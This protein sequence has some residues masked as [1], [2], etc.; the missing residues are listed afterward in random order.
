MKRQ[1]ILFAF[2]LCAASLMAVPALRSIKGEP[3]E[4]ERYGCHHQKKT[5]EEFVHRQATGKNRHSL[6]RQTPPRV[7]VILTEFKNKSFREENGKQV[8]EQ[9]FSGENVSVKRYFSDQSFGNYVPEFD[10]VGPV[11]L[12][13]NYEYYG[14]NIEG[15]DQYAEQMIIDA[16]KKADIEGVDFTEY[17]ADGDGYVDCIYVLYAGKGEADSKDENSIWPHNYRIEDIDLECILDGKHINVYVCSNE[18]NAGQKREGI[19]TAC[20]EFSHVLGLPDMYPTNGA[21]D[22]KTL[23]AWDLMDYGAYNNNGHTP[24]SYSAYE[25]WFMGWTEPYM[26]SSAMNF[27]LKDININGDCGIITADGQSNLNGLMPDPTEFV[28]I[29]NR[30]QTKGSWD[31]YL[32]GHGMLMTK[33]KFTYSRWQYNE[34]NNIEKDMSIDLIEADGFAPRY[35]WYWEGSVQMESD[36]GYRGKKGDAFP[37]GA[38]YYTPYK[39]YPITNIAE[40]DQIIRFDFCGG[41]S[42]CEVSFYSNSTYGSCST[43]SLKESSKGAGITLPAATA[44][45]SDYTFMGWATSKKSTTADAGKA[46]EKYY[47]MSDCTLYALWQDNSRWL[48][49]YTTYKGV[50]WDEGNTAY[51]KRGYDCDIY[52]IADEGYEVPTQKNCQVKVTCGNKAVG[53]YSFEDNRVHI[54]IPAAE[55]DDNIYISINNARVQ[56]GG[57]CEPYSHIF[58]GPC[59][60]GEQKLSGYYWTVSIQ[61]GEAN[62]DYDKTKGA[63][64]GSSK[65]PAQEVHL[66]TTETE[67][68]AVAQVIVNASIG[69]QGDGALNVY[70]GGNIVGQ[71]EYLETSPTEY[72]FTLA[73]P[74]TGMLDIRFVNTQKAIYVKSIDI[75]YAKNENI[76]TDLQP[77]D[78]CEY[79]IYSEDGTIYVNNINEPTN[80]MIYDAFGRNIVSEIYSEEYSTQ[81]PSGIYIIK[82]QRGNNIITKKLINY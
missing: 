55:I 46:G 29:E 66:K 40:K 78:I 26:M 32:P 41:V 57:V 67:D 1:L 33:I 36:N 22:Y 59:R 48:I 70:L 62:T 38:T 81:L 65:T 30:Q 27:V 68:C 21:E 39:N 64:Y 45:K 50:L 18:I 28:L 23:G 60:E 51:V 35:S 82:L 73:E 10:V 16:C 8:W 12:D 75:K 20:H 76:D 72:V 19:G 17:D 11:K 53:S 15:E 25:R 24:P 71:T 9:F 7:L 63:S 4:G 54:H 74:Q 58:S 44:K 61:N 2:V 79:N 31:E 6:E 69:S 43:T 56:K 47:P 3:K 34:V 49:E 37:T 13:N 52:F 42:A 5:N 77:S 80:I 14:K